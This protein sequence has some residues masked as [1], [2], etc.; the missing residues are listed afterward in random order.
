MQAQHTYL[1]STLQKISQSVVTNVPFPPAST[2]IYSVILIPLFYDGL[3][4]DKYKMH[5]KTW[6]TFHKDFPS[7]AVDAQQMWDGKKVGSSLF[8]TNWSLILSQLYSKMDLELKQDTSAEVLLRMSP[9][10]LF[11]S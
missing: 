8:N 3:H 5:N 1:L 7:R 6:N 2:K 11:R 10:L 4:A 9:S